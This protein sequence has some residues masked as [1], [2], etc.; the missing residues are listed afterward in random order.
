MKLKP[1]QSP[2]R[3]G[4]GSE[5]RVPGPGR[6]WRG[7]VLF[8]LGANGRPRTEVSEVSVDDRLVV[9]LECEPKPVVLRLGQVY[10][11]GHGRA[12]VAASGAP[13]LK[14]PR[15]AWAHELEGLSGL[16]VLPFPVGKEGR[17]AAADEVLVRVVA[18]HGAVLDIAVHDA[19][20]VPAEVRFEVVPK[21]AASGGSLVEALEATLRKLAILRDGAETLR[22]GLRTG[23]PSPRDE[24]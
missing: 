22:D 3:L 2:M 20:R 4:A 15:A 24:G 5:V 11:P 12:L 14:E 19:S 6:A 13:D 7:E 17:E 16:Q 10:E 9:A 23:L 1:P 18:G 8:V 21:A